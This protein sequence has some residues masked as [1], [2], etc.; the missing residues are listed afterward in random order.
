MMV[1][2][3]KAQRELL[4]DCVENEHGIIGAV[5]NFAPARILVEKGMATWLRDDP[6]SDRLIITD[7][8]RAT[9]KEHL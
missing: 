6:Y 2:L 8:G 1:K 7:A 4:Q 9:L 5:Y 3:T